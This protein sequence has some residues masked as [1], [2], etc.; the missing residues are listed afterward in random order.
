M[1]ICGSIYSQDRTWSDYAGT[2]WNL[3]HQ[4]ESLHPG[5]RQ[6]QP[7]S[8]QKVTHGRVLSGGNVIRSPLKKFESK[9]GDE[10]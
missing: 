9:S 5:L 6:H 4:A 7:H 8:D 10:T 1:E 3:E 2:S